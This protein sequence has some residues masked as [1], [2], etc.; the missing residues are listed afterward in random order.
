LIFARLHILVVTLIPPT[1]E[2]FAHHSDFTQTRRRQAR[3]RTQ[4]QTRTH[5]VR[6]RG[7]KM[8][9]SSAWYEEETTSLARQR[10]NFA[11]T[12]ART[13][14]RARSLTHSLSSSLTLTLSL[15]HTHI[16]DDIHMHILA[17]IISLSLSPLSRM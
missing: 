3:T 14:T 1:C 8:I 17:K 13:R 7:R 11:V 2:L 6:L 10:E 16:V 12:R 9:T 5:I 15:S 4:V